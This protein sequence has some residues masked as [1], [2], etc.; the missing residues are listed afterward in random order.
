LEAPLRRSES[1]VLPKLEKALSSML[2]EPSGTGTYPNFAARQRKILG[3]RSP[4]LNIAE[5]LRKE[6]SRF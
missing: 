4:H 5:I 3:N 2:P 1:L 6:R